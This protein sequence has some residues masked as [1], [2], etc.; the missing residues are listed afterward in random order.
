MKIIIKY[1]AFILIVF[2]VIVLAVLYFGVSDFGRKEAEKTGNQNPPE[3]ISEQYKIYFNYDGDR[4]Q[5][6]DLIKGE[7][8]FNL[9][10]SGKSNFTAK[11]LNLDGTLLSTLADVNG[12]YNKSQ[13]VNIPETGAYLLEVKTIGEWSLSRR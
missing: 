8:D 12:Q 11:L 1:A 5:I 2:T 7:A 10:Y 13:V 6:I 3:K 4:S 9:V